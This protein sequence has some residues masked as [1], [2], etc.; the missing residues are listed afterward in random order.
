MKWIRHYNETTLHNYEMKFIRFPIFM[1]EFIALLKNEILSRHG[2]EMVQKKFLESVFSN[3]EKN[4][5]QE[6]LGFFFL[7]LFLPH[8]WGSDH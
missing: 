7:K 4:R 1:K 2:K 5:V 8:V 3:F 6:I